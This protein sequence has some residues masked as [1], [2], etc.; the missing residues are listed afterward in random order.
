MSR[1]IEQEHGVC[2]RCGGDG[3]ITH[4][5]QDSA[6]ASLC[7]HVSGCI[8]CHGSGY[9]LGRDASGYDVMQ[10]C[11]LLGVKRRIQLYNLAGIPAR[12]HAATFGAF[13]HRQNERGDSN[14][15]EVRTRSFDAWTHRIASTLHPNG[16]LPDRTRGIGIQG[17]PGVGKT[18]LLA[19]V[20]RFLTLE[21]GVAVR[22]REF[23][24]L[25][26]DLKASYQ[27]GKGEDQ[28]IA[29]L[30]A[31]EV[32]LIDEL[33]QGRAS[34]WEI[35]I[36]DA[37]VGA[38]YNQG[39]TTFFA[40][41]YPLVAPDL[42]RFGAAHDLAKGSTAVETLSDRVSARIFSRLAEMCD[43]IELR[44]PDSR[45]LA[46]KTPPHPRAARPHKAPP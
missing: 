45:T 46:D 2:A 39:R 32:L 36:L 10:P 38:R 15:Y 5:G 33:G 23:S 37:I 25:L 12:Y 30:V 35:G 31:V 8:E 24:H 20:A 41:N 43:F 40:T 34:E 7:E 11:Q 17:Q 6:Q 42:K 26:W 21:Q 4:P 14:Q 22:Y 29:P 28:I 3:Y 16:R 18:H 9:R 19:A 44:G 1:C 13:E 27:S